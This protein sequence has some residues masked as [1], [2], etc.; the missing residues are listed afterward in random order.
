MKLDWVQWFVIVETVFSTAFVCYL[1]GEER[2]PVDC[3]FFPITLLVS[4]PVAGRVF[5]WW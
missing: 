4:L 5:G 3:R 1:H 2:A